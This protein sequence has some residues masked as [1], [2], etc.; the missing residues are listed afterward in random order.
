MWNYLKT[1]WIDFS[2]VYDQSEQ[3]DKFLLRDSFVIG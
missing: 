3:G 1:L 2:L